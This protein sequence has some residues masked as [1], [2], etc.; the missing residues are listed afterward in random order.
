MFYGLFLK[1][2]M[3]RLCSVNKEGGPS[4]TNC[5]RRHQLSS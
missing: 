3:S 5:S 1:Q 2:Q 4:D